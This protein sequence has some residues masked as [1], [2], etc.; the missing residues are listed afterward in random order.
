[1]FKRIAFVAAMLMIN[2]EALKL[3][4]DAND[5]AG[6]DV[7]EIPAGGDAADVQ[8]VTGGE[9]TG[10][11]TVAGGDTAGDETGAGGDATGDD[12]EGDEEGAGTGDGAEGDELSENG[13][14]DTETE[15]SDKPEG[16]SAIMT[17][18]G[19]ITALLIASA[20]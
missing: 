1:M 10:D 8:E 15:L 6:S 20:F 3:Q 16:A 18:F 9:A 7:E 11:E 14:D 13:E 19:A 5:T 4:Q 12:A 2:T 17:S